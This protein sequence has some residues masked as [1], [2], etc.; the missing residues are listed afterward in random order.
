MNDTA[1]LLV[2]YE[3]LEEVN[4]LQAEVIDELFTLACNYISIEE[5]ERIESKLKNIHGENK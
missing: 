5:R 2:A 4:R 1:K 3:K